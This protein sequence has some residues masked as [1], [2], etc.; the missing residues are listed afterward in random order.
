MDLGS[1]KPPQYFRP[2]KNICEWRCFI[3]EM[4][5]ISK[6]I[7]FFIFENNKERSPH[8][9]DNFSVRSCGSWVGG[10]SILAS[11][12]GILWRQQSKFRYF[13]YLF[14]P[15]MDRKWIFRHRK[16]EFLQQLCTHAHNAELPA[17]SN[18]NKINKSS[19]INL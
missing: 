9:G 1:S 8:A 17:K 19:K 14:I 3:I 6:W 13:F 12:N 11:K 16:S 5:S 7:L 4:E 10:N 15:G 18:S 2:L